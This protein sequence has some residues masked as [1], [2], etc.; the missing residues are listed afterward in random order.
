MPAVSEGKPPQQMCRGH[1]DPHFDGPAP[2]AG[3][4]EA[5]D[6][7]RR[8]FGIRRCLNLFAS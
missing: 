4:V 3:T 2:F 5:N 6:A 1:S 7:E 8:D